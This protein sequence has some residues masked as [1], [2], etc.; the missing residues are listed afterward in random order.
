MPRKKKV[1]AEKVAPPTEETAAEK[2]AAKAAAKHAN[3]RAERDRKHGKWG[4]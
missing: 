1:T 3:W 2:R 4:A